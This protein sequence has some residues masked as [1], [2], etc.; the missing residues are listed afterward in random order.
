MKLGIAGIGP[1]PNPE[2]PRLLPPWQLFDEQA[3]ERILQHGFSGTA[4]YVGEP[5]AVDWD[6]VGRVGEICRQAGLD[7]PQA[8]GRYNDLVTPDDAARAEG[9]RAF[10]ALLRIGRAWDVQSVYVRPGGLNPRGSWWPHPQN[11]AP[12]TFDRLVNSLRQVCRTAEAE[13]VTIGIEG[14]VLSVLYSVQRVRDV[15][16]AVG[17]PALKFNLDPVNFIGSVE[18]V[19]DTRRVINEL[20]AQLGADVVALHAKDCALQDALVLHIDEVIPGQGTM[21]YEL[22]LTRFQESCPNGYVLI[23]HLNQDQTP[24]AQSAILA[25]AQRAG[26]KFD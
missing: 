12:E 9:I 15:L 2:I 1:D 10:Q 20:F 11:R 19:Y 5:L 21:D 3:A 24:A 8:N 22:L 16:D 13:G 25:A 18:D 6:V 17:S 4:L 26:L 7:I 23:E 14:H